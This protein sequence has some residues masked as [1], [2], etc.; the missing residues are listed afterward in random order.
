MVQLIGWIFL[1][2][3]SIVDLV[4]YFDDISYQILVL[5]DLVKI[6][7]SI[8][9]PNPDSELF[10]KTAFLNLTDSVKNTI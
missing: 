1:P 8:F 3:H 4:K 5:T 2:N 9:L 10:G 6:S 7:L